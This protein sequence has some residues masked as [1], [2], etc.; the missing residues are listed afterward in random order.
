MLARPGG[1][2]LAGSGSGPGAA[3][4]DNSGAWRGW[5]LNAR[6]AAMQAS[7]TAAMTYR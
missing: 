3:G 5:S 7:G 1:Y 2:A 4:A 6:T